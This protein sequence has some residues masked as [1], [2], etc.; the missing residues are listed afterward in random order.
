MN[1][2]ERLALRANRPKE[3]RAP[4]LHS[5]VSRSAPSHASL[6]STPKSKEALKKA[7]LELPIG[8]YAVALIAELAEKRADLTENFFDKACEAGEDPATTMIVAGRDAAQRY[9]DATKSLDATKANEAIADALNVAI[10]ALIR[11]RAKS[12]ECADCVAAAKSDVH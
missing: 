10:L 9:L 5:R 4:L 11:F 2:R 12:C 6:F 3:G 8:D 1:R 7:V